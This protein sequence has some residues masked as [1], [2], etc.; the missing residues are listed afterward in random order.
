MSIALQIVSFDV[1]ITI[2]INIINFRLFFTFLPVSIGSVYFHGVFSRS[3]VL[4]GSLKFIFT[5]YVLVVTSF[6]DNTKYVCFLRNMWF[7]FVFI[8]MS[9]KLHCPGEI[10]HSLYDVDTPNT[11]FCTRRHYRLPIGVIMLRAASRRLSRA[12]LALC[13]QLTQLYSFISLSLRGTQLELAVK[14]E[15]LLREH[16]DE[17]IIILFSY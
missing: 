6:I 2:M 17:I 1:Q 11:G 8:C 10:R 5:V 9:I 15:L 14:P 12:R 7:Y 3:Y 13:S 4:S 16:G